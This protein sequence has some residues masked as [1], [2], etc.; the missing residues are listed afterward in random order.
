MYRGQLRVQLV[1][2]SSKP[3][4]PARKH[5]GPTEIHRKSVLNHTYSPLPLRSHFPRDRV[6]QLI[7]P[8]FRCS[9]STAVEPLWPSLISYLQGGPRLPLPAPYP[10]PSPASALRQNPAKPVLARP[11]PPLPCPWISYSSSCFCSW[12]GAA[13]AL[14]VLKGG[15]SLSQSVAFGLLDP[16]DDCECLSHSSEGSRSCSRSRLH[17]PVLLACCTPGNYRT[18]RQIRF[19]F[20][21]WCTREVSGFRRQRSVFLLR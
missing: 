12:V 19:S 17:R 20:R 18:R 10:H 2:M 11:R 3:V 21:G 6:H 16:R 5:R 1:L 4:P 9:Y 7:H 8:P 13:L 14:E 15:R